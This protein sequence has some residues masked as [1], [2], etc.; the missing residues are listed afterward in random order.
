MIELL[1]LG[2]KHGYDRLSV[3]FRIALEKGCSDSAAIKH[4][5]LN[6]NT[7]APEAL[8]LDELGNLKQYEMSQPDVGGY[9][10]LMEGIH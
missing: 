4:L 9:D 1:Q 3:A 6:E 5:L 2:K 7:P 10:L 8:P